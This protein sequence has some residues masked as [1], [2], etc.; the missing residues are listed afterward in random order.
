MFET[1]RIRFLS[2]VFGLFS[3]I[4]NFATRQRDVTTSPLNIQLNSIQCMVF[5]R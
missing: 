5:N 1:V 2:D 3:V 4:Q